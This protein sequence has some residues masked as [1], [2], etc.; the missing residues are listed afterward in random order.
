MWGNQSNLTKLDD[1]EKSKVVGNWD[2]IPLP[3]TK[4][5]ESVAITGG[6]AFSASPYSKHPEETLKVLEVIAS[7][8]VQKGFALAWGP[9]QYYKGLYQDKEVIE[10]NDNIEKLEPV[11]D[12]VKNRPPSK[13][14]AELSGVIQEGIHGVIT[15]TVS[16][17]E[18]MKNINQR[19]KNLD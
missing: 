9:V 1:P 5:G 6:F 17:E 11:L 8:P 3:P 19:A 14:Y 4:D 12:V 16:A 10:H 18:A 7:K 13:N 15:G 2:F